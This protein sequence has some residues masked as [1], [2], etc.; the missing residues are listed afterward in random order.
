MTT[1]TKLTREQVEARI[2]GVIAEQICITEAE[3]KPDSNIYEDLGADSLDVIELLMAVE[4]EFDLSIPDEE[5]E[6]LL[7][8]KKMT[9]YVFGHLEN[10]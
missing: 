9:D 7:T 10:A 8:L 2:R 4:E 3:I 6:E 1:T 5:T